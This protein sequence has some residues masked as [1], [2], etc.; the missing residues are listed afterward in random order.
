MKERLVA[1]D[2]CL[3]LRVD[4]RQV[5]AGV[6]AFDRAMAIAL[7]NYSPTEASNLLGVPR[8]S[9]YRSLVR[10]RAAFQFAGYSTGALGR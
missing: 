2:D 5:L 9:V 3:D 7:I 4:V 10:L 8:G 6:T 1:P